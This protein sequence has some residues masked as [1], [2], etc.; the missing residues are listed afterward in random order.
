MTPS[1][2]RSPF[3]TLRIS[4]DASRSRITAFSS[5]H[6]ALAEQTLWYACVSH[7]LLQHNDHA[8]L[9]SF[10]RRTELPFETVQQTS[11][12]ITGSDGKPDA[13]WFLTTPK[14]SGTKLMSAVRLGQAIIVDSCLMGSFILIWHTSAVTLVLFIMFERQTQ[15]SRLQD[16]SQVQSKLVV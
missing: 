9:L 6:L 3:P 12:R 5:S 11:H 15:G 10:W 14:D 7:S 13:N 4:A 8:M 2:P 16:R 1:L